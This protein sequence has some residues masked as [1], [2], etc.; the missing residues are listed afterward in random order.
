MMIDDECIQPLPKKITSTHT[1]CGKK[2]SP[3]I[4]QGDDNLALNNNIPEYFV[5]ALKSFQEKNYCKAFEWLEI[6]GDAF[7]PAKYQMACMYYEGLGR[8]EN[9]VRIILRF[10]LF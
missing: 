4:L 7:T 8:S 6:C 9:H 5:A 2:S 1:L 10:I 3:L